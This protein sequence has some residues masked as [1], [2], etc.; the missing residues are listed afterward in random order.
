MLIEQQLNRQLNN[1]DNINKTIES[2][3]DF[4]PVIT[5]FSVR[6]LFFF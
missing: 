3:H 1:N 5:I 4:P 2:F 6:I